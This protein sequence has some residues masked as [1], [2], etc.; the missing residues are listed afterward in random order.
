MNMMT[1]EF[2]VSIPPPYFDTFTITEDEEKQKE[3]EQ[4][5]DK[6]LLESMVGGTKIPSNPFLIL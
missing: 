3:L 4:R 5:I 1:M 6:F 2:A